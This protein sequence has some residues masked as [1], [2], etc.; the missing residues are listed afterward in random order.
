MKPGGQEGDNQAFLL[1]CVGMGGAS[2]DVLVFQ[3]PYFYVGPVL[4]PN[5]RL[6]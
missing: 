6:L 2:D 3:D 5:C 4:C 1:S